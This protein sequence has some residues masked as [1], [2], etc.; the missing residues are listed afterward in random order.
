ML[1]DISTKRCL[2]CGDNTDHKLIRTDKGAGWKCDSCGNTQEGFTFG[3]V[4]YEILKTVFEVPENPEPIE[5]PENIRVFLK[6]QGPDSEESEVDRAAIEI[7]AQI[8][9]ALPEVNKPLFTK[10]E[11]TP[12]PFGNVV[13]VEM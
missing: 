3:E 9:G 1:N 4:Y 11:D 13:R 6:H 7:H 8:M 10:V 2:K 5:L 12:M